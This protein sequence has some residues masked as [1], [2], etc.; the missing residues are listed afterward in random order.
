M[1]LENSQLKTKVETLESQTK[2]VVENSRTK[3]LDDLPIVV[4][5]LTHQP[6]IVQTADP[7]FCGML[8]FTRVCKVALN[9]FT[10]IEFFFFMSI[11]CLYISSARYMT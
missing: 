5:D 2:A 7:E 4:Y 3:D 6:P 10:I 9:Y 8:G 11:I 1:K